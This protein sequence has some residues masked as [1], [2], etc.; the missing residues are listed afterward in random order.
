MSFGVSTNPSR[1]GHLICRCRQVP[2][3]DN[4]VVTG[5]VTD[6]QTL[7]YKVYST[8]VTVTFTQV[9]R[10]RTINLKGIELVCVWREIK[11][12]VILYKSSFRF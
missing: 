7:G 9:I 1:F 5:P 3:W 4:S 6:N 11:M 10:I 8:T 12:A 2:K